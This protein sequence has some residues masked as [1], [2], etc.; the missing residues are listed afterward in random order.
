M[1]DGVPYSASTANLNSDDIESITVLK[2]AA[3][4]ALYGARAAN[5]V[6]MITT[7]KGTKDRNI[8]NVKYTKGI[9]SRA[10]PEYDRI[11]A[12]DYYPVMWESYHNSLV[13]RAANPL[14]VAA[15]STDAS[16]QIGNLLAYNVFNVPKTELV[17]TD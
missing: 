1:V 17:T 7:K 6:V 12:Q 4:T 11:G 10:L 9:N 2:D 14:S 3:S 15:A 13:Y 8:V 16:A 5:G